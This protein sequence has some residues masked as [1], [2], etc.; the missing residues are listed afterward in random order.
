MDGAKRRASSGWESA[1]R[2]PGAKRPAID[3]LSGFAGWSAAEPCK[4]AEALG[5]VPGK[6]RL[7]N[8]DSWNSDTY[9]R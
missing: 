5:C 2:W 3:K 8:G 6:A 7:L 4:S 1:A 9:F